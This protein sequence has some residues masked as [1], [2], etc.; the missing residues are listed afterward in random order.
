MADLTPDDRNA[1][2]RKWFWDYLGRGPSAQEQAMR[3]E[4]IRT[5]GVDLT[6]AAIVDSGE[7]KKFRAK[8]GW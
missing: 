7:A 2:V 8:R 1:M 5:Q 3:A 4:Q 6:F